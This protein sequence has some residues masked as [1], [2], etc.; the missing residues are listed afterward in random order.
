MHD[1]TRHVL[2]EIPLA[3]AASAF[4]ALTFIFSRLA[5]REATPV[6]GGFVASATV[7]LLYLPWIAASVP[8][9]AFANPHLLWF[10]G[11]GVITPSISR[12]FQFAGVQ[13]IGA[14]PSGI[15]RGLGPL[16]SSTLAVLL[17]G[18]QL[19]PVLALGTALIVCGIVVLSI[20]KDEMR[21]WALTGIAY[22]IGATLIW[23]MRDLIIRYSSPDVPY[24]TLAIFVMAG[25]SSIVMALVLANSRSGRKDFSGKGLFYF[26]LVGIA[27]FSAL[28]SLF[29]AL[30]EGRI[31]VVTPI[32]SAQP[33]FVLLF[34]RFLP[35]GME[36]LTP[37]MV[38][39]AAFIVAGG[40][41]ISLA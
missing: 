34:S 13:R 6:F 36:P 10:V 17:L 20:R 1:E 33:L 35:Q 29:F 41:L 18:E 19:T 14:A 5:T 2:T 21:S 38:L 31:V 7:T 25:T 40:A 12:T 22:A 3:V 8:M 26:V 30:E 9:S 16:F 4:F 11:L 37:L 27:S 32:T 15:L 28:T 39:G 23:V 24:K